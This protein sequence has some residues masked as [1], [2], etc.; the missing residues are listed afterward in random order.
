MALSRD[1]KVTD[2]DEAARVCSV[3]GWV[4]R[5]RVNG[6]LAITR[7]FGDVE[8]KTR[9]EECWA[10]EFSGDIIVSEPVRVEARP[11]HACGGAVASHR[12]HECRKFGSKTRTRTRSS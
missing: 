12:R 8:Y 3:G 11:V 9:K 4:H 10:K 1:H 6:V 5:S 2:A 7:S